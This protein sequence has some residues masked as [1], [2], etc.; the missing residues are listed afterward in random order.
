MERKGISG[1][2]RDG[3]AAGKLECMVRQYCRDAK[4]VLDNTIAKIVVRRDGEVE[5]HLKVF[6]GT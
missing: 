1:G 6:E 3:L 2:T 4:T 5:V